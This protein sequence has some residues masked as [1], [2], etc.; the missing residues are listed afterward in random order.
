MNSVA[1]EVVELD[2]SYG[3][4]H[5]VTGLS[6]TV[7]RGE[8]LGLVGPNG[9]GKTSTLRCLGGILPPTRGTI[10]IGGHDLVAAPV[11]AASSRSCPTSRGCST[12]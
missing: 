3:D 2:K 1:L 4:V 5:A 8:I 12:T 9:A 11:A 7:A 6:F 10:R